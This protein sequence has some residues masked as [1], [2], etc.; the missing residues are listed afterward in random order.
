MNVEVK[1]EI[2]EDDVVSII[3]KDDNNSITMR[4]SKRADGHETLN[5][6][7]GQLES[8]VATAEEPKILVNSNN[9][10]IELNAVVAEELLEKLLK[11]TN[12]I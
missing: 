2:H 7:I 8:A 12:K 5:E 1:R 9:V 6:L 3:L 4:F 11:A 10:S